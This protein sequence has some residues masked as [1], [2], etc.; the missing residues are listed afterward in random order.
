[1][2]T[3]TTTILDDIE[4]GETPIRLTDLP[5]HPCIPRRRGRKPHVSAVFRWATRGLRG[6]RLETARCGGVLC[7]TRSAVLRFYAR[8]SGAGDVNVPRASRARE[9]ARVDRQLEEEGL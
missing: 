4:E 8:L 7:T 9:L 5:A 1:M 2:T 6:H 3:H